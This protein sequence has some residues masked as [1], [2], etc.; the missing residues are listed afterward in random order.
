MEAPCQSRD[1]VAL[2]GVLASAD[3]ALLLLRRDATVRLISP[4]MA[5]LL[6]LAAWQ[7]GQSLQELRLPL[8]GVRGLE[9]VCA[10]LW[11][12]RGTHEQEVQNRRGLR[13]LLRIVPH[14]S[15]SEMEGLVMTLAEM[16]TERVL[17]QR[18][19]ESRD[20]AA[21]MLQEMP[22]PV[23]VLHAD[24]TFRSANAAFETLT[25]AGLDGKL[26]EDVAW[27]RWRVTADALAL[28]PLRSLPAGGLM[29]VEFSTREVPGKVLRM[30]SR[31]L[32]NGAD[33][34]LLLMVED[35]TL[36]RETERALAQ[37]QTALVHEAEHRDTLLKLAQTELHELA[38]QLFTVQEQE[39]ER[40]ARELHDDVSQRL[41]LLEMACGSLSRTGRRVAERREIARL[42]EQ[43]HSLA[44][45]VRTM[46]HHLHPAVLKQ[47]GL[48][49]AV[50]T[51]VD[52]FVERE[53]LPV[54][55]VSTVGAVEMSDLASTT[56]YRI[57]QEA[58]RNVAKHAGRTAVHVSLDAA[59]GWLH[60]QVRDAGR[61]F[62]QDPLVPHQGLG[63]TSMRERARIA[64]G[65]FSITSALGEGTVVVANVPVN[66]VG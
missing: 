30:K 24:L 34:V 26:L 23:A 11:Q 27:R 35:V 63:L 31:A 49:V 46:S 65:T 62:N 33:R 22:L 44:D 16:D 15:A 57:V 19:T 21:C 40:I 50:H 12:T 39:R 58:L 54:T 32:M 43:I 6:G 3:I 5:D 41:S 1:D 10:E 59:D 2:T 36:R 45:D 38:H 66:L 61:G 25:E 17:R 7:V 48:V 64:G 55:F 42:L 56:C 4:R 18:L 47:L 51:L 60:L 37:Q 13:Y 14:W 9:R 52:A 28:A 53:T 8:T 20:V 29:E